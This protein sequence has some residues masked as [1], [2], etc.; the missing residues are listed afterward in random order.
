LIDDVGSRRRRRTP[1]LALN[2]DADK[3]QLKKRRTD[4]SPG[5]GAGASGIVVAA[6]ASASS[7]GVLATDDP[8]NF[9][10][11]RRRPSRKDLAELVEMFV[12]F[13]F[14]VSLSDSFPGQV[15]QFTV[16][17][18]SLGIWFVEEGTNVPSLFRLT[19]HPMFA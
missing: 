3:P 13:R 15:S 7:L 2:I 11:R 5:T 6:P 16:S 4:T 18:H 9:Q 14:F 19:I 10:H 8:V 1:R 12:V 17:E